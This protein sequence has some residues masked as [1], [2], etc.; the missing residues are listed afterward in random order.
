[1]E[2]EQKEL[3]IYSCHKQVR[4][5]KIKGVAAHAENDG[6]K[7]HFEDEGYAPLD[8]DAGYMMKHIPMAGGYYVIYADGYESFSPAEAFES[9]YIH[10]EGGLSII[11]ERKYTVVAGKIVNRATGKAIPDDEPIMIFRAKDRKS[12]GMMI[13]YMAMCEDENHIA[14]VQGRMDDFVEW[15]KANQD[16]VREP[17]SDP[18]C[19]PGAGQLVHADIEPDPSLKDVLMGSENPNGWK[20]G[21]L[22]S[23]LQCEVSC[24]SIKIERDTRIQSKTVQ[25]N[26]AQIIGLLKQAEAIQSQ[27]YAILDEMGPNEGPLGQP[28]IG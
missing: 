2:T 24:K 13:A 26:N 5:L 6:A 20:L 18:S 28:R 16:K 12:V 19:L 10:G 9:G 21:E 22:L 27:S 1:M 4:A 17:D 15:Q 23:Q 25:N 8:V 11:Q 7:L 3:P 14:V